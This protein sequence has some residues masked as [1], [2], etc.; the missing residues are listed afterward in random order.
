MAKACA[1]CGTDIV[2]LGALCMPCGR[3]AAA[4]FG[5]RNATAPSPNT[6]PNRQVSSPN[7]FPPG[8]VCAEAPVDR[9]RGPAMTSGERTAKWRQKNPEAHA[10]YMRDYMRRQR[11]R[12]KGSGL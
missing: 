11:A 10:A 6:S 8:I 2:G 5:A 7:E 12:L 1:G 4:G 3:A 9:P